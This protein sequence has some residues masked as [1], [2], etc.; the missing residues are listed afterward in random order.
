MERKGRRKEDRGIVQ[1]VGKK[2]KKVEKGGEL[3]RK[4]YENDREITWRKKKRGEV[5]GKGEREKEG[6]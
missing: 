1:V 5:K 3:E 4:R 6:E 2:W